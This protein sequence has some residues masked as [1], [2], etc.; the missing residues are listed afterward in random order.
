MLT[1]SN[2]ILSLDWLSMRIDRILMHIIM[3]HEA[4]S[5]YLWKTKAREFSK[6]T[7]NNF[8]HQRRVSFNDEEIQKVWKAR[9]VRSVL[10]RNGNNFLHDTC[11]YQFPLSVLSNAACCDD[12][13]LSSV[14]RFVLVVHPRAE[15]KRAVLSIKRPQ[16][17]IRIAMANIRTRLDAWNISTWFNQTIRLMT[18]TNSVRQVTEIGR[19]WV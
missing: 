10:W 3:T 7:P 15:H 13:T 11:W 16:F 18:R 1:V 4:K 17:I 9:R 2:E 19:N 6:F 12:C 8:S 14:I 5:F